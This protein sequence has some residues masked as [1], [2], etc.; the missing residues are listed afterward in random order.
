M[1]RR[2]SSVKDSHCPPAGHRDAG[3][4]VVL[5]RGVGLHGHRAWDYV[6]T[7]ETSTRVKVGF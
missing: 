2:A 4:M 5:L 7:G 3:L 1:T 6:S